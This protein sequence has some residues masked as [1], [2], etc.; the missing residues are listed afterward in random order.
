MVVDYAVHLYNHIPNER[1]IAP[2]DSFTGV[3]A[4]MHKL[5]D[6]YVWDAPVYVLDLFLQAGKNFPRCKPRF[7]RG[8]MGF[9]PVDSSDVSLILNLHTGHISRNTT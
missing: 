7:R 1:G 5:K 3:T 6:Y 9:S 2:A 4:P 8:M